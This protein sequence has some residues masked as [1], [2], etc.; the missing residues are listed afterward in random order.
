MKPYLAATLLMCGV[1]GPLHAQQAA[2][3]V[4]EAQIAEYKRNAAAGC[5]EGGKQQGDPEAQVT[6]FCGC[7]IETLSKNMTPAEWRQVVFYSLK[8][9][10]EEEVKA[11]TPHL[12][13][14]KAC[15]P[16]E[17]K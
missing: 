15:M 1:A 12:E 10:G 13:K 9:Q 2:R 4:T 7:L 8:K 3:N 17:S 16:A 14:A 11:L 6:A 5:Q